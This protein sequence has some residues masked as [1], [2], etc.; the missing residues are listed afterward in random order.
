MADDTDLIT[1][2]YDAIIDASK[3]DEVVKRIVEATKSVSG[4]LLIYQ[5]GAAQ[6]SAAYK[7]DPFYANAYVETWHEHNPLLLIAGTAGPGE[8]RTGTSITQTDTYR[9][10]VFF[11]EFIRPQGWCDDIAVC[12]LR[13]PD[14]AGH[15]VVH[16]SPNAIWMEPKEWQLFETLAPHLKRAAEVHQL[17]SRAKAATVSLGAAIAEAGF[18]VFLLTEDCS[19]VFANAK[20]EDLLRHGIGLRYERGR[21]TATSSALTARLQA[22][23]RQGVRPDRVRRRYRRHA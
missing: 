2:I 16:R 20:A 18:A 6:L 3:W 9:S 4:G 5:A 15:L 23:A 1:T 13:G 14:S 12:L 8:L 19:V 21:L 10:S 17:L 7:I 22:L 11:N